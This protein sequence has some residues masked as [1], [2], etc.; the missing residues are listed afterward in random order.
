MVVVDRYSKYAIFIASPVDVK[1]DEAARLFIKHVVKL[2]G[3]PKSIVSDGRALWS[4]GEFRRALKLPGIELTLN[5]YAEV[6]KF[7]Q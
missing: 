5:P 7:N 3:V 2:W 4:F 6:H 1:V